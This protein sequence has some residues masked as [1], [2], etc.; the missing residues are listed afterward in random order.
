MFVE[1]EWTEGAIAFGARNSVDNAGSM[2]LAG[3]CRFRCGESARELGR[4]YS[5]AVRAFLCRFKKLS[6]VS[7]DGRRGVAG[8][9]ISGFITRRVVGPCDS[10]YP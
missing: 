9:D 7:S 3:S 4:P 8:L 6:A 1:A 5:A 2:L 10:R